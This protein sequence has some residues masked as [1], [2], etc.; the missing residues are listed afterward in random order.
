MSD[1][2]MMLQSD[3]VSRIPVSRQILATGTGSEFVTQSTDVL[4]LQQH[5][6]GN[7]GIN[8]DRTA[9]LK[10]DGAVYMVDVTRSKIVALTEQGVKVLSDMNISSWLEER[11]DSMLA[12]N[13]GYFVS[14]GYDKK[15]NEVVFS[16]QNED[17][18]N[19][20]YSIIFS[21]GLDKFTT[22]VS[23]TSPFYGNLG[24]RFF[25]IRDN[26]VWEAEQNVG[27]A[28]FFTVRTNPYI[29]AVFN[30]NPTSRKV[31]DSVGVDSTIKPITTIETIDQSV[32][33]PEGAAEQKEG[34]WYARVPRAEGTSSYVMLGLV[35]DV[36]GTTITMKNNIN[37]LP[38]RLGGI[39]SIKDTNGDMVD[40]T[41]VISS[42]D[43]ANSFTVTNPSN[44][45][46]D[47]VIAIKGA[48]VDGD[49]IRGAYAEAK[50]EF[51]TGNPF[52][53]FS[54]SAYTAES[55]L[56]NSQQ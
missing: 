33:I 29:K 41:S 39:V 9:F 11:C 18:D 46:T 13:D 47:D 25:H 4:G 10:A 28:K 48:S 49:P 43:S 16:L 54:V 12:D 38:F 50:F 56:H 19:S 14:I 40:S 31:Y 52:E 37:R 3:K 7:F 26:Q 23:Y 17:I 5:Y 35:E 42:L 36:N 34:V 27:Y 45:S 20:E 21:T 32:T 22:F 15:N 1:S 44:I 2:I 53:L 6:K 30:Q 8:E 55:S 51:D 24:N